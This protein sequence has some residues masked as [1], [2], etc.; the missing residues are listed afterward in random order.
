MPGFIV[1][2][3]V[4]E[5]TGQTDQDHYLMLTADR[6]RLTIVQALELGNEILRWVGEQIQSGRV[7]PTEVQAEILRRFTPPQPWRAARGAVPRPEGAPS[8]E[9]AIR[10]IREEE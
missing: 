6:A 3:D 4:G 5:V 1:Q 2:G 10:R 9:E 8:A 7:T